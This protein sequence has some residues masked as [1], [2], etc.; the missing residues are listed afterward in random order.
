MRAVWHSPIGRSST[1]N[2]TTWKSPALPVFEVT[3]MT[4]GKPSTQTAPGCGALYTT[5]LALGGGVPLTST[6]TCADCVCDPFV[7]TATAESFIVPPENGGAISCS[8]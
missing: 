8:W 6:T 2:R 1:R 7:S 5:V 3:L 4:C